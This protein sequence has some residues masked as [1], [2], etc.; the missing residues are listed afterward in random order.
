M[1]LLVEVSEL[2]KVAKS[3]VLNVLANL[4]SILTL[5]SKTQADAH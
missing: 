2:L 1:I 3:C 5:G 4:V